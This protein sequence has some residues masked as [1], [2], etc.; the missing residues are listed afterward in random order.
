MTACGNASTAPA[1]VS[2]YCAIAK[3]ISY[4]TTRDSPETVA[5]IEAANSKYVCVCEHDCP[6]PSAP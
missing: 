5:E 4:D 1:V 3:P 6:K 2:D